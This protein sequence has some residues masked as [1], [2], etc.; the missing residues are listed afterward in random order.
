MALRLKLT[1]RTLKS[2]QLERKLI[3]RQLNTG[4]P[5]NTEGSL[6]TRRPLNTG[7]PLN[8]FTVLLRHISEECTDASLARLVAQVTS[9]TFTPLP[10]IQ[11]R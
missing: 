9:R 1:G 4:R 3:S 11:S 2:R 7:R 8:R 10:R 6:N 5:L